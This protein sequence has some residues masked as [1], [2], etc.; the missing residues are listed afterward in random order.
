MSAQTQEVRTV[1]TWDTRE[2][3]RG[4]QR[5]D[6]AYSRVSGAEKR[7]ANSAG[8]GHLSQ[9]IRDLAEGRT[10]N[11]LTRFTHAARM[12]AAAVAGIF[13]AYKVGHVAVDAVTSAMD[14]TSKA[15]QR[16]HDSFVKIGRGSTFTAVGEGTGSFAG[17]ILEAQGQISSERQ[18]QIELSELKHIRDHNPISRTIFGG[19]EKLRSMPIFGGHAT[20]ETKLSESELRERA[21]GKSLVLLHAKLG[22]TLR[23]NLTISEKQLAGDER[24]V[25]LT[26]EELAYNMKRME[27]LATVGEKS[28]RL[29]EAEREHEITRDLI[30]REFQ[31]RNIRYI[32]GTEQAQINRA[33]LSAIEKRR[34][35]TN[36][37]LRET[38]AQLQALGMFNEGQEAKQLRLKE[39]GLRA[40]LQQINHDRFL[41]E[42][43]T[44]RRR[45]LVSREMRIERRTQRRL[46]RWD[47]THDEN[48]NPIPKIANPPSGLT[49]GGLTSGGLS[50]GTDRGYSDGSR[51]DGF[52]GK[53]GPLLNFRTPDADWKKQFQPRSGFA[54]GRISEITGAAEAEREIARESYDKAR[55]FAQVTPPSS[56][57]SKAE[58]YSKEMLEL[59]KARLPKAGGGN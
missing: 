31:L 9:G 51:L 41:N 28:P 10:L 53:K 4:A 37:E 27:L 3:E 24:A 11:S 20:T 12:G 19:Y 7:H 30:N 8:Q 57:D 17:K 50:T 54:K 33:N 48:G 2:A 46:D 34:Q 40:G 26:K 56:V 55:R 22:D 58:Q 21:A 29:R 44:R 32:A 6:M 13:A 52:K 25:A 14:E 49:T 38:R 59:L 39:A 36:S 15:S 16:L 43:G 18:Q 1:F 45:G 47:A 35:L 23:A 5:I 42:N